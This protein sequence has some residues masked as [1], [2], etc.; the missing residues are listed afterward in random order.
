MTEVARTVSR[1]RLDNARVFVWIT[2]TDTPGLPRVWTDRR[3][4]PYKPLSSHFE[5]NFP[6]E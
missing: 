2:V 5:T 4:Q 1:G 3:V 6:N